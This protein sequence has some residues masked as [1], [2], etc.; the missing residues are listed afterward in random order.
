MRTCFAILE[1]AA[2]SM[3]TVLIV[4]ETGTGKD[5]AAT[6]VARMG[7]R[8]D[9][10][11]VVV[12]C[13][14]LPPQLLEAELFGYEQ[15]AFTG[16]DRAHPGAF[17]LAD[18][19]T[20]FLDEIG[21]LREDLQPKLLRVLEQREVRRIGA[22]KPKK[23]DVRVI[24]ATNRDLRADVNAHRFRS[25]LFFRLAVLEVRL[26]PLR[27]RLQDLPMLAARIVERLGPDAAA[28]KRLLSPELLDEL[29][30]YRWPGNVRELRNF[31]ERRLALAELARPPFEELPAA[32]LT[33][34]V[35]KP[36][37]EAREIVL[38]GFEAAYFSELLS[39]HGNNATAAA[40]AAGIDRSQLYRL[41][42]RN[43]LR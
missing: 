26:P 34:D 5:L 41:L 36:L 9:A 37:R 18:G 21:D 1:R 13:S 19:G 25:D 16:A 29:R 15:G 27:D 3:S 23:V 30:R 12:D 32:S 17:E 2:A 31:L 10:E 35:S 6:S 22:N 24:A 38:R 42:W 40:R 4:G 14:A 7:A 28:R 8:G 43:G 20:L 11:L 39:R 33:V